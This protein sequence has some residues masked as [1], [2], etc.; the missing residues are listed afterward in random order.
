MTHIEKFGYTLVAN[1]LLP[2]KFLEKFPD[3]VYSFVRPHLQYWKFTNTICIDLFQI[4]KKL[5]KLKGVFCFGYHKTSNVI[6]FCGYF[7]G[8]RPAL[9]LLERGFTPIFNKIRFPFL[10]IYHRKLKI[11]VHKKANVCKRCS[12]NKFKIVKNTYCCCI[13]EFD[14]K[15]SFLINCEF[16][17][18][19]KELKRTLSKPIKIIHMKK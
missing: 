12:S 5:Y 2:S 7:I 8:K 4:I 11:V 19:Q 10:M 14:F 6:Y 16:L 18:T 13:R 9:F 1:F 17:L 15:K 3:N